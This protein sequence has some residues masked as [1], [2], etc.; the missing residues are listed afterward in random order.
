[1]GDT[2]FL[3]RRPIAH[4]G[5]HDGNK[6]CWE[7]TLSAFKAAMDG[8]FAIELDVHMSKDGVALVFHDEAL[9]RLTGHDGYIHDLSAAEAAELAIGGTADR[10]PALRD[11]LDLVG[12]KVPLVIEIKGNPGH[13][14]G[15]VGAVA[16]ALSG[17][18]GEAAIM[19]FAHWHVRKF[20]AEAPLVAGGLTAEG[21]SERQLEEHFAMLAHGIS[22]VSFN[23]NELP[24]RFV[25]F[26]RKRLSMPV[27]TWTVRTPETVE[28]TRL[29]AD[30]MTFEGFLPA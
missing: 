30:Q 20:A 4:R 19:S 21:T 23:V 11:V 10:I 28:R 27:I 17:Y 6:A 29:Y 26:V 15:L 24:N 9:K 14:A 2:A 5:L 16:S 3:A 1:M 18:T 8:G 25:D 12:G 13:D 22:F 7:N